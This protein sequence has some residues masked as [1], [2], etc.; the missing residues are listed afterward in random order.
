MIDPCNQPDLYVGINPAR[1]IHWS[2]IHKIERFPHETYGLRFRLQASGSSHHVLGGTGP[3]LAGTHHPSRFLAKLG[4][5]NADMRL[6]VE[7]CDMLICRLT[8]YFGDG[9]SLQ[10]DIFGISKNFRTAL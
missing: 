6:N 2:S 7:L 4:S 1:S 5:Y 10:P 8:A 3:Q 9:G